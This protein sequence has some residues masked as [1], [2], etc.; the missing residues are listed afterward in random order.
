LSKSKK[1]AGGEGKSGL[2]FIILGALAVLIAAGAAYL[3]IPSQ[4]GEVAIGGVMEPGP[5]PEYAL[6]SADAPVTVIE[7]ASM[8]CHHCADFHKTVLPKLKQQYIDTGKVRYILREFP[9]DQVAFSISA[10][11][12]CAGEQ[13]FYPFIDAV[14]STYDNWACGDCDTKGGIMTLWKQAGKSEAD[15]D[16]CLDPE[17]NKAVLAGINEIR[18]KGLEEYGVDATPTIFVNGN[19]LTGGNTI[20]ELEK[21]INPLLG[22]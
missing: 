6:G 16:K 21:A 12:R 8:T 9:G 3:Y 5:L 20:E 22:G 11:A 4:S 1:S 18:K 15:F 2:T 10:L 19:K 14:F 7:Y 17:G 13:K